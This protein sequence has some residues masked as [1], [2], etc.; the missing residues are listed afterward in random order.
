MG[1]A[2]LIGTVSILVINLRYAFDSSF[3]RLKDFRFVSKALQTDGDQEDRW[4]NRFQGS[5]LSEIPIPLPA[6]YVEGIDL[7]RVDF[8]KGLKS[9]LNGKIRDRGWW[10][11]YLVAFFYKVPLE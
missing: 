2:F 6:A 7:Q 9:Y 4:G 5:W 3:R 8:K 1:R 10:Y 11:Y